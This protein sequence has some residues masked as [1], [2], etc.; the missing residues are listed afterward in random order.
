MLLATLKE[1]RQEKHSEWCQ[2]QPKEQYKY[3]LYRQNRE[4]TTEIRH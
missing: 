2:C 3:V 1:D 4:D